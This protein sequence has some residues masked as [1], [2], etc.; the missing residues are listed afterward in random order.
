MRTSDAFPRYFSSV[1]LGK[2]QREQIY[3]A[4]GELQNMGYGLCRALDR[5]EDIKVYKYIYFLIMKI[6]LYASTYL[7]SCLTWE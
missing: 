6:V 1:V 5:S 3:L 4:V 2:Q 7:L